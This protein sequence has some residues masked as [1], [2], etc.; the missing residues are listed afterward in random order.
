MAEIFGEAMTEARLKGYVANLADLEL[1]QLRTAF[2]RAARELK[3]FPKVVE[4]RELA[5]VG[6]AELEDAETR[7]A[8]DELIKFVRKYVSNDPY[9]T[10]GPQFGWHPSDYPKLSDRML[11]TVRRT[12]GWSVYA[13]VTDEDFPF[14]QKRFFEEY[15]AWSAVKQIAPERMLTGPGMAKFK[16]LVDTKIL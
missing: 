13:C 12:G 6:V 10:Y 1:E 11:D 16:Q 7:R 5:G 8:W 15:K 14:V 2:V 4:L 9:G 3:F